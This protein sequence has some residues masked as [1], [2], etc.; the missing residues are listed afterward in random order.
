VRGGFRYNGVACR[1]RELGGDRESRGIGLETRT[2]RR[3]YRATAAVFSWAL[4][5]VWR[6]GIGVLLGRPCEGESVVV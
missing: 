5:A 1:R 4:R 3:A 6:P 2:R